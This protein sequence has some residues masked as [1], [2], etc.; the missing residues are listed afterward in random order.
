MKKSDLPF[1]VH[2]DETSTTQVKKQMDLTLRYWS[3]THNE[4]WVNF[5]TSLFFG[6]AEGEKVADRIFQTMV[7]DDLPTTKLCTLVRDGPNVNKAIFRKL[8]GAIK[9]DNPNFKGFIDLGSCVL[10]NFH[11]AFGKALEE[12][13]KDIE[14]LC[15][16]IHS[17]FKYSAA[18][19]EDYHTLQAAMGV[20]M[21]NFQKHTEVRW[22]SLGPCVVRILEQWDC[23]CS[24]VK[25]LGKDPKTAPKSASYKRVAAMLTDDEGKKTKAQLEFISNVSPIFEDFLTIFQKSCPQVHIFYDK[26]SE[27]LHKVMGRF[28]KKEAYEKKFGSDLVS[29]DCSANNQLPD[30]DISIGDAT[31]KALAQLKPERRKSVLLGIRAFY[32]TS[33]TY[34]QSHLPL[35]NT[36]LKALGCLNPLKREK[37]SSVKAIATL[38]KKL[39][40]QL[41]VSN[42]QDEWRVYSVDQEVEQLEK[43]QRVDHFWRAVFSLK[44][45]DGTGPRFSA[46]PKVVKSGL[47]LAQSNAESER[48]L[49]VNARIVTQERTLLGERTIVGLRTVKD[50][51]KFHDP[52]NCRPE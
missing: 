50:A 1:C 43:G 38:A 8:E 20:E 52:E 31:K 12:Y 13:G 24:F 37:A 32:S 29:I 40:P 39:Q 6:H 2:F 10:H 41:D 9:E 22:L 26:M 28:L 17:L 48:C 7:K 11:N 18:R 45:L 46:I 25:D 35:Q 23:I 34:L 33:V 19:R 5:Y 30:S 3:P 4:V 14:Q 15:V 21:H 36:L 27:V 16:D 42:V 47:I 44:S 49:S 51:V